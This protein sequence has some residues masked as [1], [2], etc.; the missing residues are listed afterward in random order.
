MVRIL[1]LVLSSLSL[2][3]GDLVLDKEQCSIRATAQ[4]TGHSFDA[5]PSEYVCTL[6][7]D[8]QGQLAVAT[9]SASVL[10]LKTDKD[11]RD[12]EMW[13]W[14]ESDSW[15]QFGFTMKELKQEGGKLTM[16][17]EFTL[18]NITQPMEIPI[19]FSRQDGKVLIDG[20]VTMDTTTFGL[21]KI[22]KMAFLTVDPKL[23]VKFSLVATE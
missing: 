8:E 5:Y 13:R 15:T 23:N 22:R 21:P 3:A 4:A 10:D 7:L 11:G 6:Q 16:V 18:H 1:L 17:G 2:F 14:L 19:T 9:F 12:K 20:E